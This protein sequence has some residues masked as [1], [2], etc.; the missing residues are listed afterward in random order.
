MWNV[1]NDFMGFNI[2]TYAYDVEEEESTE[3]NNYKFS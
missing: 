3:L 2:Q 1:L